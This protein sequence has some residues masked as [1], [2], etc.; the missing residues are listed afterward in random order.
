V[1]NALV[2]A[3]KPRVDAVPEIALT[4]E[5]RQALEWT[6]EAG[7]RLAELDALL[8]SP[9]AVQLLLRREPPE[10]ER[11][12]TIPPTLPTMQT[13]TPHPAPP[14]PRT[15]TP[16]IPERATQYEPTPVPTST[17]PTMADV[18]PPPTYTPVTV[19]KISEVPTVDVP[20]VPTYDTYPTPQPS[21]LPPGWWRLLPPSLFT[22]DS[23][24]GAYK[25]QAGK[26]QVL[27]LA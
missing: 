11:R 7:R 12:T 23:K 5:I 8:K 17:T 24:E 18:P 6:Q 26:R 27:L 9:R 13:E 25:V 19:P 1:Q 20:T 10:E 21:P 2:Y 3:L 15:D 14:F 22:E 4:P 16:K